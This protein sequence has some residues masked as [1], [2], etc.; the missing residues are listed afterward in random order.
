[1]GELI[2]GL[3]VTRD[4]M[5]KAI[6]KQAAEKLPFSV[7]EVNV[8][9]DHSAVFSLRGMDGAENI[10][11]IPPPISQISPHNIYYEQGMSKW[12]YESQYC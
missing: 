10:P 5:N 12:Y 3:K 11:P 6:H 4:C 1:M 8:V 7:L 2:Q 9:M